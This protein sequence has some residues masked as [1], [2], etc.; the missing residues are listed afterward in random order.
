MKAQLEEQQQ[1]FADLIKKQ[2]TIF[3]K[4][5]T[6]IQ[7]TSIPELKLDEEGSVVSFSG[8]Q[9]KIAE[10]LVDAWRQLSPFLAKKIAEPLL[11]SQ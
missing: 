2:I 11:A 7:L 4:D 8:E 9:A 6:S 10:K 3:G 1:C 5:I